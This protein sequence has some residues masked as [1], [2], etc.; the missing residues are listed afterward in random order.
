MKKLLIFFIKTLCN[1]NVLVEVYSEPCQ[2]SKMKTSVKI[3]N[4]L[5][6]LITFAQN[7]VLDVSQESEY[8]SVLQAQILLFYIKNRIFYKKNLIRRQN[9]IKCIRTNT[10]MLNLILA[11]RQVLSNHQNNQYQRLQ[12][13][14]NF[15]SPCHP[16]ESK[17]PLCGRHCVIANYP[18]FLFD[19]LQCHAN[20]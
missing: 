18:Y 12:T 6:P 2:T 4:F 1:L 8:V 11:Q 13:R 14:S 9:Q 10:C 3:V 15:H 7:L 16:R 17:L 5:K 20:Y 19:R